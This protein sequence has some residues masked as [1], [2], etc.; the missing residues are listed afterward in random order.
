LYGYPAEL[1][2]AVAIRTV[3]E[4]AHDLDLVRFVLFGDETYEAFAAAASG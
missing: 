2:A 3:R 4:H 1:A